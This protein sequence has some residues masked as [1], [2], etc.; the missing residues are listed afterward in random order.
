MISK[1]QERTLRGEIARETP[2]KMSAL[3]RGMI[4]WAMI[5][6]DE[7]VLDANVGMGLIAE[8]LKR[9][10]QCEVCGVSDNME[11]VR[12]ARMRLQS[13]DIVYATAGD[14]PWR[15]D[16]F[17]TAMMRMGAMEP[18]DVAKR[19][20]ELS[21]VLKQ[22]GQL[23]LGVRIP[24]VRDMSGIAE[25]TD[26]ARVPSRRMLENLLQKLDFT[27]LTYQRV[28]LLSGVLIA[29]KRKPSVEDALEAK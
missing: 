29:W 27:K 23:L 25:A 22:G 4:R 7:K 13:C 16:S 8:Y 17:D 19:V 15:E 26:E 6:P 3:E 14:I 5:E 20:K 9:N 24:L 2:I 1:A 28:G 10:A 21:R 12:Q 18:E 11:D